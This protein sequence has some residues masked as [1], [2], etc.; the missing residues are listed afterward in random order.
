M[1]DVSPEKIKEGKRFREILAI[2]RKHQFAQGLTPDKLRAIFEDLG[3]TFV[4]FGQILSMRSD[5]LPDEY[6]RALEG[7]RTDVTPLPYERVCSIVS[8]VYGKPW[9]QVFESIDP[10]PLGS[11]S[12]AQVHAAALLDGTNV[13]IKV[14]RPDIRP[15]ME[16]DIKLMKRASGI[17]KYTPIGS[18][19]DFGMVLDEMYRALNDELDFDMEVRNLEEFR[20]ANR[21]VAY[22]GCPEVFE[23]LCSDRIIVMEHIGGWQVDDAEGLK[24]A[25]YDLDEIAVKLVNNY[26]KQIVVDRFFHADPHPG[27]IRISDGKIIWLDLGMMGRLSKREAGLYMDIITSI[28]ENDASALA[29]TL[30]GMC[31]CEKPVDKQAFTS[32]VDGLLTK[33]KAMSMADINISSVITEVVEILNRSGVSIPSSL[34]MLGRS[35]LV[36]QGM[37]A[38]VSPDTNVVQIVVDYVAAET[39]NQEFVRKRLKTAAKN[40]LASG[41]KL[42]VLPSQTSEFL[43]K[44]SA[45]QLSVNIKRSSSESEAAERRELLSLLMLCFLD[46]A[47]IIGA[48]LSCLAPLPHF[49]GLPWLGTV[50]LAGA[51]VL[52]AELIIKI[53]KRK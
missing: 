31:K 40:L 20:T 7:L 9:Q 2:L 21:D 37:L 33:Y 15:T 24:A 38:G 45:G 50:F 8:E 25:G 23:E 6:C 34:T 1:G 11:A 26:I 52:G 10:V 44:A 46:C 16:R 51:I 4:K 12:I 32:E 18:A 35:L 3:P 29:D 41:D 49:L 47:L 28:Y 43:K 17:V 53:R 14:Q 39:S 13:V 36:I 19:L 22:V 48:A 30:L 27:N 5:I 42:T